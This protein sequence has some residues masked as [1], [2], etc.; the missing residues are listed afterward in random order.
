[1][2]LWFGF[3]AH[4]RF[5]IE[6]QPS[7]TCILIDEIRFILIRR[8]VKH[9]LE[10]VSFKTWNLDAKNRVHIST[11]IYPT[12][13]SRFTGTNSEILG[14]SEKLGSKFG[15]AKDA[16]SVAWLVN[17]GEQLNSPKVGCLVRLLKHLQVLKVSN[18][19]KQE[20]CPRYRIWLDTLFHDCNHYTTSEKMVGPSGR[21]CKWVM[22]AESPHISKCNG[23]NVCLSIKIC[24]SWWFQLGGEASTLE[25]KNGGPIRREDSE[26]GNH[27]FLR[28]MFVFGGVSI[29]WT[30]DML[31]YSTLGGYGWEDGSHSQGRGLVTGHDKPRLMG[32]ASHR[33]FPG[34]IIYTYLYNLISQ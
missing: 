21:S 8:M 34:G 32:V 28:F 12:Y 1:M 20:K 22:F 5:S 24:L 19:R 16:A 15:A 6:T 11:Y 29:F 9:L 33:S 25:P 7:K 23:R 10:R 13:S 31:S 4:W 26:L 18:K 27:D 30:C 14:T 2:V 17:H 3:V